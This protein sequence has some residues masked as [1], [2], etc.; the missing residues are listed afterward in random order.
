[1][2]IDNEPAGFFRRLAALGYDAIVLAGI[3]FLV[4][5]IL[6]AFRGGEA[7]SPHHPL[8]TVYLLLVSF[9]FHGWCWTHGGQTLGMRAWKIQVRRINGGSLCWRVAAIRFGFALISLALFGL[10]FFRILF[11]AEKRGWHDAL[12]GTR[13]VRLK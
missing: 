3:L 9:L 13:V 10:G 7:F 8:Y 2:T 11:D 4:T 12:S 1:M 6:L 5:A